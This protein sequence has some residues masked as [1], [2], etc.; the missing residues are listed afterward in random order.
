MT[1]EEFALGYNRNLTELQRD[2]YMRAQSEFDRISKVEATTRMFDE[3]QNVQGI[4]LPTI[5][6]DLELPPQVAPVTGYKTV[7]R[8]LSYRSQL[9]LEETLIRTADHKQVY[10]NM[11]DMVES[12]KTLKDIV[13]VNFFN[14]GFTDSLATNIT[15]ADGVARAFFSTGHVYENGN[16]TFSNYNNVGVPP[17]PETVYQM[18]NN[19]LRR[20]KDNVGN[21]IQWEPTFLIVTPTATPSYGLA[22]DEIIQSVDRP[23]TTN[24]ATNVLR[25]FTLMHLQLN[26]LTSTTKWFLIVM[27]G[28]RAYP[29]ITR[30]LLTMELTPLE[31][32]GA[33]NPHAYV[34]TG[35]T[36]FGVGFRNSYRGATAIGT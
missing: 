3:F 24:R 26:Q 33:A 29:L 36:Q 11:A 4:S 5:N 31:R 15:E 12:Y 20:L 25:N 28:N 7:I 32:V 14:N 21:F 6:R 13:V 27:P 18:I 22:A 1:I 9:T 19:Y 8:Q 2:V 30:E 17:N 35:R 10:E 34:Q 16:G 23:D